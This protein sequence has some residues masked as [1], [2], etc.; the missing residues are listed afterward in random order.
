MQVLKT[1]T[2]DKLINLYEGQVVLDRKQVM[3][4]GEFK[5][6]EM[7]ELKKRCLKQDKMILSALKCAK[8][9]GYTGEE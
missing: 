3:L 4:Y 7:S 8:V 5:D 1:V 6:D 2:L 9:N